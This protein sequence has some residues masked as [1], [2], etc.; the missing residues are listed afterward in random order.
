M[1]KAKKIFMGNI[2][3]GLVS[4]TRGGAVVIDHAIE[5]LNALTDGKLFG[6]III[7]GEEGLFINIEL[8]SGGRNLL[9]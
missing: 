4:S 3:Q 8:C 1:G 7:T 2:F 5:Q 9:E 6:S